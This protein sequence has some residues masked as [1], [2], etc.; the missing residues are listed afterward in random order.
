[1]VWGGGGGGGGGGV[2]G[3]GG[4]GGVWF[5]GLAG[6]PEREGPGDPREWPVRRAGGRVGAVARIFA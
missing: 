5:V 2:W 4:G 1:V 6:G 3:G